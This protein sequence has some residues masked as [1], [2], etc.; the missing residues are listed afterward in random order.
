MKN[1]N[2]K[3]EAPG[4]AE[5]TDDALNSVTG[6]IGELDDK[7]G[8][9]GNGGGGAGAGIGGSVGAAGGEGAAGIGGGAGSSIGSADGGEPNAHYGDNGSP[10]AFR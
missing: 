8:A 5:L 1:K 6:G 3:K 2:A 4:I 10:G 7:G 9:G